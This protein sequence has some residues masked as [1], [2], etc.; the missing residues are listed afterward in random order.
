[1]NATRSGLAGAARRT[2]L[3]LSVVASAIL[4]A[5]PGAIAGGSKTVK[6]DDDVYSPK[7]LKVSPGTKVK[8]K[9]V[10]NH[11][12]N[13]VKKSGPGGSFSSTTTSQDGVQFTHKFKKKG[14][15]KLICTVH[16]G[17]KMKVKVH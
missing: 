11:T 14:T 4:V 9:W 13:V 5:A 2:A 15:Y 8:F 10:G 17:M 7:T 16:P 3:A 1:V 6:V 12:H